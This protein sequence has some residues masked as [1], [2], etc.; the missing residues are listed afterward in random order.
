MRAVLRVEPCLTE[1]IRKDLK[2]Y[3]ILLRSQFACDRRRESLDLFKFQ[4]TKIGKE[5][6]SPGSMLL[7]LFGRNEIG[8]GTHHSWLSPVAVE[9]AES[10]FDSGAPVAYEGCKQSR[11]LEVGLSRLIYQFLERNP[12]LIR[13]AHDYKEIESRLSRTADGDERLET[14][15]LALLRII[16]LHD[17][18]VHI[19]L[20][21]PDVCSG[22]CPQYITTM[23]SLIQHAKTELKIMIVQRSELWDAEKHQREIDAREIDS[24]KFQ[25]ICMN[26]KRAGG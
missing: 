22:S 10:L 15:R 3:R 5:W 4:N 25:R 6:N 8:V 20:D 14:L 23:L 1:G 9:L 2:K 21:R 12:A 11:S 18:R 16:D 19:I 24:K 26:Q 13:R 7:L 17:Q